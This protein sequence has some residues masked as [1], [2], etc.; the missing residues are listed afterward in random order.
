MNFHFLQLFLFGQILD[1]HSSSFKHCDEDSSVFCFTF[2]GLKKWNSL[3][4]PLLSLIEIKHPYPFEEKSNNF[5]RL[6]L[7]GLVLGLEFES[8]NDFLHYTQVL[9]GYANTQVLGLKI[10]FFR[11]DESSQELV[12]R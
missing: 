3:N 7:I 2:I 8:E 10:N 1:T 9:G 4:P 5:D 11:L 12:L 6:A